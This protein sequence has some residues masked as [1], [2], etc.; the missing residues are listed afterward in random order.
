MQRRVWQWRAAMVVALVAAGLVR[1]TGAQSEMQKRLAAYMTAKPN[2]AIAKLQK[3]IDAG[4]VTLEFD[5]KWGYLPS[6]LTALKIPASSQSLVFSK[7]SFQLDKISP[8]SPRAIYFGDDVYLGWVLRGNVIEIADVDP[9]LG[10]VFYTIEQQAQAKPKFDRQLHNCLQ[11][12]DSVL[13]TGGVPGFVM[14][15]V[16]VDRYGYPLPASHN[17]VSSDHSPL[18]EKFGGWWVSGTHGA[19]PHMGN[20]VAAQ[21]ARDIGNAQVY[22]DGLDLKKTGNQADIS[23]RFNSKMYYRTTS[24]IVALSLLAHQTTLHNLM[25]QAALDAGTPAADASAE[26]LVR[27]LLF[28]G[29]SAL[30]DRIVGSS[31]FAADFVAQGPRDAQGRSLRE[32]DL[33]T[34]LMKYPLSYLIYSDGFDGL[35][36][37]VKSYVGRRVADVLDGREDRKEFATMTAAERKAVREILTETRPGLLAKSTV[38]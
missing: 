32:L 38:Q 20:V 35:P 17:P 29:E 6:L 1:V 18:K 8:S 19:Q 22:I 10:A 11:C 28:I 31:A 12:H 15:S 24:D 30:T 13:N 4:E 21:A 16:Y 26:A 33:K 14:Q 2:D 23:A 37:S 9:A 25:T 27:G 5:A 36:A 3:K 34:R 7:T